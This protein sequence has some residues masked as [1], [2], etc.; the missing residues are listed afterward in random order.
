MARGCW[1]MRTSS[2]SVSNEYGLPMKRLVRAE[3]IADA[4]L[5]L[6]RAIQV[7]SGARLWQSMAA[8]QRNEREQDLNSERKVHGTQA[9]WLAAFN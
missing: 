7:S 9:C 4:V 2:F 8:L 3:E 6:F 5:W 1:S